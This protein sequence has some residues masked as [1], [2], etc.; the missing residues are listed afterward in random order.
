MLPSTLTIQKF[1]TITLADLISLSNQPIITSLYPS[2][3]P[4]ETIYLFQISDK[5]T[6]WLIRRS[7]ADFLQLHKQIRKNLFF[8]VP[9]LPVQCNLD[10][11][12]VYLSQ[13]LENQNVLK[14]SA[15]LSFIELSH[16]K[17]QDRVK[18]CFVE[19]RTGGRYRN[20]NCYTSI[21]SAFKR[22]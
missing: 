15:F 8:R 10:V 21:I 9:F 11:L 4:N 22:W 3:D 16:T 1:K 20:R 18:E 13:L 19:K 5:E 14:C 17:H 6:M 7:Y 12:E 2:Y